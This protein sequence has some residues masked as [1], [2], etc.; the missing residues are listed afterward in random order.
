MVVYIV[1]GF[2]WSR[3]GTLTAPG[4]RPHIV[5]NDL[6][7]AASDYIQEP[8]T[9]K[10]VIQSFGR[11]DANI[12]SHL[13][14]LALIEQYD[15]EDTRTSALS[16]P[17]AFV[18]SKVVPIGDGS[19]PQFNSFLSLDLEDFISKGPGLSAAELATFAN[20]REALAPGEKIRWW[21]VYNGNPERFSSDKTGSD[22]DTTEGDDEPE[23]AGHRSGPPPTR[24]LKPPA[25]PPKPRFDLPARPKK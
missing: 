13:P 17:Y 25:V 9:A 24:S 14:N 23:E 4:I 21:I 22:S 19:E 8:R 7:D 16:Q 3:V 20:L 18:C 10:E 12:P 15:P 6:L 5:I 11:I 1:Y 2:R